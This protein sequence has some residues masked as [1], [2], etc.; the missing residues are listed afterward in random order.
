MNILQKI[1]KF[2]DD[3]NTEFNISGS[4]RT[5]IHFGKV[6]NNPY[7]IISSNNNTVIFN[8]VMDRLIQDKEKCQKFTQTI[9]GYI[10]LYIDGN[11]KLEI[12]R[13]F[14]GYNTICVYKLK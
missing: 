10:A 1:K 13:N 2:A 6:I 14:N 8:H 5:K 11:F 12:E 3:N 9:N 7:K 4:N